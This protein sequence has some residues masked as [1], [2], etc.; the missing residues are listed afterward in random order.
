MS[1]A[2]HEWATLDIADWLE[3]FSHHPLIGDRAA[4]ADRFPETAHLSQREQAGVAEA[5]EDVLSALAA[6]NAAYREHFGHIFIICASGLTAEPLLAALRARL[7]NDPGT[8]LGIAV[9]EQAKITAL[10]LDALNFQEGDT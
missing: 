8:E 4:L 3:A 2:R 7:T 6:E 10:R 9:E 5:G 1:A